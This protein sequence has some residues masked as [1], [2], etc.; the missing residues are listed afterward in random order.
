[1]TTES[2]PQTV[3][4]WLHGLADSQES[5]EKDSSMM[6]NLLHRVGFSAAVCTYGIVYLEGHGTMEAPPTSIHAIA[7]MLVSKAQGG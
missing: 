6:Q 5:T 2:K 3:K 1:M 7:K 4:E